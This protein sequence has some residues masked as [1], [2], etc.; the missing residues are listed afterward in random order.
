MWGAHNVGA[1]PV[2]DAVRRLAVGALDERQRQQHDG[3]NTDMMDNLGRLGMLFGLRKVIEFTAEFAN[4]LPARLFQPQFLPPRREPFPPAAH[5][6]MIA[7]PK[8]EAHMREV[9]CIITQRYEHLKALTVEHIINVTAADFREYRMR[10]LTVFA[11]CVAARWRST[12][13]TS[14]KSYKTAR[15]I[16]AIEA[17]FNSNMSF[18]RDVAFRNGRLELRS[19]PG[20]L[21]EYNSRRARRGLQQVC[22]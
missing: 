4:E 16:E 1:N 3:A 9:A 19:P 14:G 13:I 5:W 8:L 11:R 7:A 21:Q 18:W 12:E 20:L 15:Q 2:E 6:R 10:C 17:A 22:H